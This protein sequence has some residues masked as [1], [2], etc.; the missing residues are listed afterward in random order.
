MRRYGGLTLDEVFRGEA[1]G[2]GASPATV[3]ALV[4]R[5]RELEA[6]MKEFRPCL[7]HCDDCTKLLDALLSEASE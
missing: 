3:I 6:A 2:G 5:V 7:S 1:T 4:A